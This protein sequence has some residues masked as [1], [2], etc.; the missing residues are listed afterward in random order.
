MAGLVFNKN[1]ENDFQNLMNEL[2]WIVEKQS[3]VFVENV[4]TYSKEEDDCFVYFS[5]QGTLFFMHHLMCME[6]WCLKKEDTLSFAYSEHSMAFRFVFCEKGAERRFLLEVNNEILEDKGEKLDIENNE[7]CKTDVSTLILDQLEA[8]IGESFWDIIDHE[9]KAIHYKIKER[10]YLGNFDEGHTLHEEHKVYSV[11]ETISKE[12]LRYQF[13]DGNLIMYLD[14]IIAFAQRKQINVFIYPWSHQYNS[15][16]FMNLLAI[17]NELLE[18]KHLNSVIEQRMSIKI[19]K[20]LCRFNPKQLTSSLHSEMLADLNNIEI[21]LLTDLSDLI[22]E[23]TNLKF[24]T[25][26]EI[27]EEN[28]VEDVNNQNESKLPPVNQNVENNLSP[29]EGKGDI[30][31]ISKEDHKVV[32]EESTSS[33]NWWEFWKS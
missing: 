25:L 18:R 5:K 28:R 1:H 31:V 29:S 11:D 19:L 10:D 32:S 9:G 22:D 27:Q 20:A 30:D 14:K 17:C 7:S 16:K 26:T 24:V 13:T 15:Q 12:T 8:L 2:G 23:E 21:P 33:K 6:P 4:A 3:E